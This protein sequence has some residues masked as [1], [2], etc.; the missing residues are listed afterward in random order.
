MGPGGAN[1]SNVRQQAAP[2]R[3]AANLSPREQANRDDISA[4]NG[5]KVRWFRTQTKV[6]S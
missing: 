1:V 2:A 5:R 3:D 4:H 6:S